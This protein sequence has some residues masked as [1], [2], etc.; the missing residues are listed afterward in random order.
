VKL[1]VERSSLDLLDSLPIAVVVQNSTAVPQTVRF[2]R[3]IEYALELRSSTG[4]VLWSS[5][6]RASPSGPAIAP[7]SRTFAPGATTLAVYDWNELLE[8]G[9]SPAPGTYALSVRLATEKSLPSSSVRVSFASPIS[10][11][12]LAALP[13][14]EDVTLSGA[15]DTQ[16]AV[17]SDSRGSATLA[18]RLV[19]APLDTPV[20]VRGF[21]VAKPDGTRVFNPERWATASAPSAVTSPRPT[22]RIR[23]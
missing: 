12:S 11:S 23:I 5:A 14:G 1:V 19:A 4:T 3:P 16:R 21:V 18:R 22:G 2:V 13:T 6:T 17:L 7:H 8:D 10:P 15:L 20:L 9:A